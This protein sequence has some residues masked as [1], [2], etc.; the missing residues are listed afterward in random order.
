MTGITSDTPAGNG[1]HSPDLARE[2]GRRMAGC[3]AEMEAA[4][5]SAGLPELLTEALRRDPL[6]AETALRDAV[7]ELARRIMR[8][9]IEGLDAFGETVVSGGR[10]CRRAEPTKGR[11]M[12][13]FGAVD[14]MRCRYRPAGG[15]PSA[16]PAEEA[17]GSAAHGMTPAAAGWA[18]FMVSHLSARECEEF[19]R[20]TAGS[21]PAASGFVKLSAA[22]GRE[23]EAMEEDCLAEM[24]REEEIPDAARTVMVELDGVMLNMAEE[25]EGPHA[26]PAGW[27]EASTGVVSLLDGDGGT[28]ESRY[29]GRLPESG[30]TG[31]KRRLSAEV[32]HILERRPDLRL[33]AAADAAPCNWTYLDSL[34]PDASL[35]DFW[36]VCQHIKV[37]ADDAF[38]AGSAAGDA[39]F[40]KRKTVL[41]EEPDGIG[42][43]IDAVRYLIRTGRGGGE[44]AREL[45]FLRKNRKRMRYREARDAG[46]QVGSGKVESANKMLVQK[47]MKRS[48][49]RWGRDGGQAVLSLQALCRSGRFAAA[50]RRLTASWRTRPP[51][52]AETGAA[53]FRLAA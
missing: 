15:G 25:K 18:L 52:A 16:F 44:T 13:L 1:R 33:A 45:A 34:S 19:W 40:G 2:L 50:E 35:V 39:W 12:T 47:R 32:F 27:R 23:W 8:R 5:G 3:V 38:G 51:A 11:A 24:R 28:L 43:T 7:F 14:F 20:R 49:Q 4:A 17:L 48:G 41:L 42:R 31:L 26:K 29:F 30:M 36:H 6:S 21:G 37:C 9:G 53:R 46:L 10:V 22:A